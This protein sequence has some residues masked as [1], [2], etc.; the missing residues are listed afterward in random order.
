MQ[1]ALVLLF[2]CSLGGVAYAYLGYPSLIIAI[3]RWRNRGTTRAVPVQD[4]ATLP[5]ITILIAAHNAAAHITDRVM[6]ILQCDYPV[7]RLEV[8]VASDGSTDT[9]VTVVQQLGRANVRVID[10][11]ERQGKL[12]TIAQ[13]IEQ[14]ETEIVVL[15]DASIHFPPDALQRLCRHFRDPAVGLV[16]G[17]IQTM[18]EL[19]RLSES[20]YWRMELAVRQAEG[21]LGVLLGASGAIYALRRRLFVTPVRAVINDDLVIPLLIQ[22]RH[23]CEVVYDSHARAIVA[24][25]QGTREEFERRARIGAGA[26]QA[27]LVLSPWYRREHLRIAGMFLSHK[28]SRWLCP[29][30]LPLA[31]ISN[32]ILAAGGEYLAVLV[33]HSAFYVLAAIGTLGVLNGPMGR[34]ANAAA[35]F[36]I[37][38]VALLVG[39]GR[40]L[41]RPWNTLWQPTARSTPDSLRQLLASSKDKKSRAA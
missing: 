25:A 2:W 8:I 28:V 34:I 41:R 15:T 20:I 36:V 22:L 13:A 11:S 37:M 18:D 12:A 19:G 16:A 9:T 4:E 1:E 3:A 30:L 14:C 26:I 24:G 33:A 27:V 7:E 5:R 6:N 31:L 10:F 21:S 32:V 17:E 35:S 39:F 40:W 29:F 23:G 38:N